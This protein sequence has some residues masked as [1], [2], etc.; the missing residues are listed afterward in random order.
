MRV[1]TL[2]LLTL[3][4]CEPIRAFV[5][6]HYP[7]NYEPPAMGSI[8]ASSYWADEVPSFTGKDETRDQVSVQLT[9]VLKGL[10]QPTDLVFFP[11]SDTQGLMLEKEG[12]L[13]RFDLEK[14]SSETIQ[15]F[16]VLTHSEQG[17]LG[18]ALHP[19]FEQN[20]QF[21]LHQSIKNGET[22]VGEV[23]CWRLDA[24][25]PT[26]LGIVI[27]VEQ[28]YPNHNAG[29]IAFGPDGMFYMGLGD[30]GW[31]NDPHEHGQNGSTLLGSMLRLDVD[32]VDNGQGYAIPQDNPFVGDPSV[33]DE[34]WA[35]GL[36]NPWKFSFTPG[37]Q[38]VVAD[39]G[40]N[41]FEE[42]S[43]VTSGDNLGWHIREG[44]HCFPPDTDCQHD[45]LVDP[46]FE[47]DRT[48]G[49]SIT[50]GFVASSDHIPA[51]QDHYVFGDFVSG[52]LWAVPI[53]TGPTEPLAAAKALGQW[54]FL[55]S[56]FGQNARGRLFVADFG[57]GFLYRLDP[58]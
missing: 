14:A 40:Q 29:Q 13:S 21:Y 54:P 49:Q 6:S 39:V 7:T 47:Y 44:R 46:I 38:M 17:L 18:I 10:E 34:A 16:D 56:T 31:R 32:S 2:L 45:G 41:A 19:G 48:E 35:T 57:K 12:R 28:P 37:G 55:P 1:S 11:G 42:V 9:P 33:A 50:G 52:R 27:Q 5:I 24:A 20:R 8:S 23:S 30:G 25:G 36:R 22:N 53:D 51:I 43:L 3:C 58:R 26:R 4:G 15:Q